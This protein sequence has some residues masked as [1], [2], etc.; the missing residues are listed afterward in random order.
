MHKEGLLKL[1]N[2]EI[3]DGLKSNHIYYRSVTLA[4][5]VIVDGTC[6]GVQYSDYY[7]TWDDVVVQATVKISLK[8]LY[9]PV[10]L[11]TGKIMVKI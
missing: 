10:K 11:N 6:K 5:K 3:I 1:G 4:G 9:I 2:A 8:T 7:G